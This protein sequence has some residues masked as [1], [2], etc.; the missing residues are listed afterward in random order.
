MP[1]CSVGRCQELAGCLPQKRGLPFLPNADTLEQLCDS[2][3][4]WGDRKQS[5]WS[6]P[7]WA[8]L[9]QVS[10]DLTATFTS[11]A[12]GGGAQHGQFCPQQA[13][14]SALPTS[15]PA[16]IPSVRK[17]GSSQRPP[18]PAGGWGSSRQAPGGKWFGG[19]CLSVMSTQPCCGSG[20]AAGA[21]S[22]APVL[23]VLADSRGFWLFLVALGCAGTQE[24]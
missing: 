15:S 19:Q 1:T 2:C 13:P 3:R 21:G 8:G 16:R 22:P 6:P 5:T 10:G 7:G 11:W 9:F 12:G 18:L 20:V 24:T 23:L 17:P 14:A 4:G